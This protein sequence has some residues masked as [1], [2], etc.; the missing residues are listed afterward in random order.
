MSISSPSQQER[1]RRLNDTLRTTFISGRVLLTACV[2][3]LD[4]NQRAMLLQAVSGFAAFTPS[5]DPYGEHD[6]GRVE[7]AG[8]GYFF[9]IDYY[10]LDYRYESPDPADATVTARVMTIMREDE[11]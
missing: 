2:R 3:A 7:V 5:N 9:K 10:D 6:F 4:D 11:Y 8:C 1:I